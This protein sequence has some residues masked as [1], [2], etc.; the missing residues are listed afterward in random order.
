MLKFRG[1][2]SLKFSSEIHATDFLKLN[3][4]MQDKL[5]KAIKNLNKQKV[6]YVSE[7]VEF[8]IDI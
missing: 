7:D 1:G 2:K 6:T 5:T 3:P 8:H 4:D